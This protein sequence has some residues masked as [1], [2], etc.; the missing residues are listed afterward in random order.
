MAKQ[1][2]PIEHAGFSAPTVVQIPQEFFDLLPSMTGAEAKVLAVVLRHTLGFGRTSATL[3]LSLLTR[4]T[5]LSINGAKQAVASLIEAGAIE[6]VSPG[7]PGAAG[8]V[9]AVRVRDGIAARRVSGDTPGPEPVVP[10]GLESH[11]SL[12]DK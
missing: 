11:I 12:I 5:G 3:S 7:I 10:Q 9:Y 8:S 1:E 4:S 2:P 6:Q